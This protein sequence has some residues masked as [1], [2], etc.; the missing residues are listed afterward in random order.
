M[1]AAALPFSTDATTRTIFVTNPSPVP[2][3]WSAQSPSTAA[4]FF[5]ISPASGTLKAGASTKITVTF[6]RALA[7]GYSN[8][9]AFPETADFAH[10]ATFTGTSS[11]AS[12]SG[13]STTVSVKLTGRVTRPPLVRDAVIGYSGQACVNAKITV[14]TADESG[15][16]SV[17]GT[18]K[19][20]NNDGTS[21]TRS[22]VFTNQGD[23]IGWVATLNDLLSKTVAIDA[24]ATATD[25][26]GLA[27]S[28]TVSQKRPATC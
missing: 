23:K 16:K 10:V 2:V 18:A 28:V 15:V 24:A 11:A 22:L 20:I 19:L 27:T 9:G 1:N 21:A 3:T 25:N 6:N 26:L 8:T 17:V 13:Q 12:A 4:A 14:R 7:A 5:T